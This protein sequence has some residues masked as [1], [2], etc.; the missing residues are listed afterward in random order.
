MTAGS[1]AT[2]SISNLPKAI[3]IMF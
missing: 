2:A 1:V 3:M